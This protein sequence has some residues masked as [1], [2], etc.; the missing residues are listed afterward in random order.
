[1]RVY[2]AV[3]NERTGTAHLVD[4]RAPERTVCGLEVTEG[5]EKNDSPLVFALSTCG[6]CCDLRPEV[7]GEKA[8]LLWT[9]KLP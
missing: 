3:I 1:M 5:F 9:E 2:S 6:R 8:L 7:D 4:R